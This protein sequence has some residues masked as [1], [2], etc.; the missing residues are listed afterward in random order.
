M[1]AQLY[2]NS[3]I[4]VISEWREIISDELKS[5]IHLYANAKK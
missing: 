3:K 2:V 4:N 1:N 5:L